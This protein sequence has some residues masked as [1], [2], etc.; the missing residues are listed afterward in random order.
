MESPAAAA[1]E[2]RATSATPSQKSLFIVTSTKLRSIEVESWSRKPNRERMVWSSH[3]H[4]SW[5]Q[6]QPCHGR[7][8]RYDMK[9]TGTPAWRNTI[10][11]PS[12]YNP[13]S[14]FPEALGSVRSL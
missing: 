2:G 1:A 13:S 10:P 4:P 8:G 6:N 14:Q 9:I 3:H 7:V 11:S 12:R 5:K